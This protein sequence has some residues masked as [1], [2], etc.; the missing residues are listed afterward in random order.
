[1]KEE[2]VETPSQVV[3]DGDTVRV[4]VIDLNEA[5]R[6]IALSMKALA[7]VDESDE[8]SRYGAKEDS[9]GKLGDLLRKGGFVPAKPGE[10]KGE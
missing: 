5:D 2:R 7:R 4:M 6:K 10:T 8:L 1:M 9:R 3:N